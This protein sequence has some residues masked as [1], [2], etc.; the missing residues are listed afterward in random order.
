MM[1]N[2][3]ILM[4]FN[5][6]TIKSYFIDQ[7]YCFDD[8]NGLFIL[9]RQ[10]VLNFLHRMSKLGCASDWHVAGDVTLIL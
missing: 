9:P 1:L 2:L 5:V 10:S 7:L 6:K 3:S 4:L 8:Q